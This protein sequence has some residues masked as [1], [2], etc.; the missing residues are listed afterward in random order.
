MGSL[1]HNVYP[2][3]AGTL[4]AAHLSAQVGA[5]LFKDQGQILFIVSCKESSNLLQPARDTAGSHSFCGENKAKLL[6]TTVLADTVLWGQPHTSAVF[7]QGFAQSPY[8]PS[9]RSKP[10]TDSQKILCYL[11]LN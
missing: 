10:N 5:F 7:T 4:Q 2:G 8:Q 1:S 9:S 6:V 11:N 3:D